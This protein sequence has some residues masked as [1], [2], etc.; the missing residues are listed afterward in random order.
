VLV[1]LVV[2]IVVEFVFSLRKR[3]KVVLNIV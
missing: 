3:V 1:S 2:W